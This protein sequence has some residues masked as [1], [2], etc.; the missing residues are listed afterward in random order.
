MASLLS[1]FRIG[2][3]S[4]KMVS[5]IT[6]RPH[7]RTVRFFNELLEGFREEDGA[8]PGEANIT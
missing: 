2:Y 4:L 5:G 7:D 8:D 6:D 3:Q 1:K